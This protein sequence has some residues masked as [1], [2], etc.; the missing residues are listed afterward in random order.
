MGAGD[1][2]PHVLLCRYP[3]TSG[4]GA[5]SSALLYVCPHPHPSQLGKRSCW[6]PFHTQATLHPNQI[7][8]Q[9]PSNAQQV[10][11]LRPTDVMIWKDEATEKASKP[12]RIKGLN[13]RNQDNPLF[14]TFL[15]AKYMHIYRLTR[16]CGR[17]EAASPLSPIRKPR[18]RER[19]ATCQRAKDAFSSRAGIISRFLKSC[20]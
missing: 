8:T 11:T 14:G 5:A 18:H 13:G 1:W 12:Q 7:Q 3:Q 4:G 16:P 10:W 19:E 15:L 2:R 20:L 17:N 6:Q 9:P